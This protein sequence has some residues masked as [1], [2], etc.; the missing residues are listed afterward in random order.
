VPY[1]HVR[2]ST[3]GKQRDEAKNDI[4]EEALETQFLVPYRVGS[5]ITVN[6][7]VIHPDQLSR[8]QI[9]MSDISSKEIIGMLRLEDRASRAD[10]A[11]GPSYEWR[12][13]ARAA[14]VTD[15]FITGPPGTEIPSTLST[16]NTS[17]PVS[18]NAISGPGDKRSVFIVSGRDSEATAGVVHVLRAMNLRVVE[19]THAVLRT[20]VPNPYT[21]DV[22]ATGLRMADAALVIITPDDV[23]RLRP[24]LL[25]EDDGE[26]ERKIHGQARPNVIYEAGYADALGR[27]R[28]LI[29][30]IGK[31]KPFSDIAGRNTLHYDG[32]PAKRKELAQRLRLA[33]LEPDT[34]GDDWLTRGDVT[35]AINKADNAIKAERSG[36]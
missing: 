10:A 30:E 27:N 16:S 8:I 19:W 28:T 12:A 3:R 36:K 23:V 32:S 13:A 25:Y 9:S 14:D 6:G 4:T 31:S 17:S 1:Y 18:S 2:I 33:G 34:E 29:I 35:V 11:E 22:V 26:V 5:P 20:G 24:D 15:Q 7:R 21:G